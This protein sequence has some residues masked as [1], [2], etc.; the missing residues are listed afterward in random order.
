VRSCPA[1]TL[2]LF[3]SAESRCTSQ[4]DCECIFSASGDAPHC[5]V[6]RVS[7][8]DDDVPQPIS[9]RFLLTFCVRPLFRSA[10]FTCP[11]QAGKTIR[12][13]YVEDTFQLSTRCLNF[14]LN[15]HSANIKCQSQRQPI[16]PAIIHN[17]I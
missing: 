13:T 1:L 4:H 9:T 8:D 10:P 14:S 17:P 3:D 7:C 6:E 2:M 11:V 16:C 15:L 5:L 12:R